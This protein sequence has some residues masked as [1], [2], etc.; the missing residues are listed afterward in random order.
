VAQP[1][2]AIRSTDRVSGVQVTD[3]A[4]E[5]GGWAFPDSAGTIEPR[6][7]RYSGE[8]VLRDV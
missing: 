7:L 8:T 2:R 1:A 3:V 4:V 5:S 6:N